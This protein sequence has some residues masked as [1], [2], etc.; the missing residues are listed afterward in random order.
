MFSLKK[1]NYSSSN[2]EGI[3]KREINLY[4]MAT[5]KLRKISEQKPTAQD[6]EKSLRTSFSVIFNLSGE[7]AGQAVGIIREED[8]ER[9]SNSSEV[10]INEFKELTIEGF[11]IILGQFLGYAEDKLEIISHLSAP[12]VFNERSSCG[13]QDNMKKIRMISVLE[14]SLKANSYFEFQ[15]EMKLNEIMIPFKIVLMSKISDIEKIR[16]EVQL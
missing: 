3:L 5:C 9:L 10:E 13:H 7:I 2:S 16:A 12:L 4:D 6:L 14:N 8:I 15:Y 1:S 11:N